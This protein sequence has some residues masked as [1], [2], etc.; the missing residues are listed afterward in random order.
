[1]SEI[2]RIVADIE[3]VFAESSYPPEFL[4]AYDQME[5][6]ANHSGRE[7]FLVR[8]KSDGMQAVAKCYDRKAFPLK[9]D[10]SLLR[11]LDTEGLPKY[12]EEFSNDRMLCV[13]R[14]YI[15]GTPL[16]NYAKEK[17]L[18]KEEILSIA[19]QLCDILDYLH[20]HKPSIIHRDV[21]PENIIVREDGRIVL[22]DFDI[23]RTVSPES[24]TDSVIFGT[25][26]YAPPEQYGFEQTDRRA[27]IF[28]F[29]V[30][31]RWMMTGSIRA[32][33]NIRIDPSIQQTID[34][35]TAFSPEDRF[36]DIRQ[37]KDSLK[38]AGKSVVRIS[39]RS[40]LYLLFIGALLLLGLGFC[41]GRFTELFKPAASEPQI[42]FTEPLIEQAVRLQLGADENT[43]LTPE[44]LSRV[45]RL[46]IYGKEAYADQDTY[47]KQDLAFH[48][49]GTIYSLNDLDKLPNL[50]MFFMVFQGKVDIS[51]LRQKENLTY[52]E[53]KHMKLEDI[54]PLSDLP[55]LRQAV[56]FDVGLSDV[57]VLETCRWMDTLD[58]GK[59]PIPSMKQVGSYPYVR[60]LSLR[61]ITMETLDGI[62][63]FTNLQGLT[64]AE[65]EIA[66]LSAIAK[67]PKLEQVY[68]SDT[69]AD[70]VSAVLSGTNVEII[71][72]N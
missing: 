32:N 14:E 52:I 49:R 7:T 68:V 21:K 36:D 67:L 59:N 25:R 51:A 13:V 33:P 62:E 15:D 70:E 9:P 55:M 24:E 39:K 63:E 65:A 28:A 11:E 5:C 40:L 34:R 57:T 53:L 56:L 18:T 1:M 22:I 64:L 12:Y 20:A 3:S 30:L 38:T 42:V 8:R 2:K 6:L 50:E 23:A 29:G 47:Y 35:C 17:T 41:I 16:N 60:S 31:L 58:I 69:L 66:D 4:A 54:Y 37:V 27:D 46:Y 44:D 43:V 26:G 45:R 61:G 72:E 10:V 71:I 19:G 48:K